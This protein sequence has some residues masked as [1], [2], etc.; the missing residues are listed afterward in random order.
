MTTLISARLV[1]A[2]FILIAVALICHPALATEP[3][4]PD[5]RLL[6]TDGATP[7]ADTS[8]TGPVQHTS[9]VVGDVTRFFQRD[10][11]ADE[12]TV[13]QDPMLLTDG[14]KR[15][16]YGNN[17]SGK[18]PWEWSS[19]L[20]T[21]RGE[22][23]RPT[24]EDE[25]DNPTAPEREEP[26]AY[27]DGDDVAPLSANSGRSPDTICGPC[28]FEP[29]VNVLNTH[30]GRPDLTAPFKFCF[31]TTK[32]TVCRPRPICV[33]ICGK[34][35]FCGSTCNQC[36]SFTP[37]TITI[38]DN[39]GRVLATQ[40]GPGLLT[41][42]PRTTKFGTGV[43]GCKTGTLK[44]CPPCFTGLINIRISATPS[45]NG[46]PVKTCIAACVGRAPLP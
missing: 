16:E 6:L 10:S 39:C 36:K 15:N 44:L 20:D 33:P 24:M 4:T 8:E 13:V 18:L 45:C 35:M 21:P 2:T 42:N 22:A 31:N 46:A 11:D 28:Q 1:R 17:D 23:D 38:T 7:R 41:C 9:E 29:A 32:V 43:F 5:D 12:I 25:S 40:T 26:Q 37:I 34:I 14:S 3:L 19:A 30:S 27:L